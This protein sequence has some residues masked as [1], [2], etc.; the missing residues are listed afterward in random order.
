M[1]TQST[2]HD[3]G[4]VCCVGLYGVCM[5]FLS[6]LLVP[7]EIKS[8]VGRLRC[9]LWC[10]WQRLHP[11]AEST[12]VHLV[13]AWCCPAVAAEGVLACLL[14][15]GDLVALFACRC[16]VVCSAIKGWPCCVRVLLPQLRPPPVG[17]R[18]GVLFTNGHSPDMQLMYVVVPVIT[19]Y[20][21][22]AVT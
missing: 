20:G 15:G 22:C 3:S 9:W 17:G 14:G 12:N 10:A 1:C 4:A 16:A 6:Q 7:C 8:W 18:V 11:V 5:P 13:L 19:P 21:W 2:D